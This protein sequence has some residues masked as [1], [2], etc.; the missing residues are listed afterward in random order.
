MLTIDLKPKWDK[1]SKSRDLTSDKGL[2]LSSECHASLYISINPER[3]RYL[4]L[5]LPKSFH[6]DLNAVK[7]DKIS[8]ELD[9]DKNYVFLTLYDPIYHDLFDDLIISLHNTIK[10]I[11]EVDEY[12]RIFVQTYYKWSQFFDD[13]I[14]DKLSRNEIQ[15]LFGELIIL[16]SMLQKTTASK[17]NDVLESWKGPYDQGHDF[18][19]DDK[20]IEV[21]TQFNSKTTIRI[22]SENQLESTDQRDLELTVVSVEFNLNDGVS[23]RILAE[24]INEIAN[25]FLGDPSIFLKALRQKGLSFV[26]LKSYDNWRFKTRGITTYDCLNPLFPKIIR[27]TINSSISGVK[28]NINLKNLDAFIN[29]KEGT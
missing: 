17:V 16:K 19:L 8:I 3:C 1:V 18:I 27:S 28:Y 13:E 24:N 20:D 6:I 11:H 4:I 12:S 14:L 2:L 26:N 22:S 9:R 5:A 25:K 15:G 21:K 10:D 7:K 23:I 29:A